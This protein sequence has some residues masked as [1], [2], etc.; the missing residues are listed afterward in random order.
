VL[1]VSICL[2]PRSS[3]LLLESKSLN[4]STEKIIIIF[5]RRRSLTIFFTWTR[6]ETFSSN[7]LMTLYTRISYE[8]CDKKNQFLMRLLTFKKW[9][10]KLSYRWVKEENDW[11]QL[12]VTFTLKVKRKVTTT[13]LIPAILL[14][15][16][17]TSSST[18]EIRHDMWNRED[19]INCLHFCTII[20]KRR[21]RRKKS[22]SFFS[23]LF[24][25]LNKFSS[26]FKIVSIFFLCCL[27]H[28]LIS[29][30]NE[31]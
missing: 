31:I 26:S 20:K 15:S 13:G 10:K 28:S 18:F 1:L 17:N 2:H 9:K 12:L 8:S 19:K 7:S 6:I 21:K 24:I 30:Q 5:C 22:F 29:I 25:E 11:R 23:L 16:W 27:W 4:I 3:C 14:L